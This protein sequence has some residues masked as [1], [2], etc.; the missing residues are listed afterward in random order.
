MEPQNDDTGMSNDEAEAVE[1]TDDNS[2]NK[3]SG[4]NGFTSQS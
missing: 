1:L 4:N 3:Q 2:N